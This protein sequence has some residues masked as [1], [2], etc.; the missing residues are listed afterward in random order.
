MTLWSPACCQR[1]QAYV[2]KQ[3]KLTPAPESALMA[4]GIARHWAVL[5]GNTRKGH[6]RLSRNGTVCAALPDDWFTRSAGVLRL[7]ALCL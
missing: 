6:W 5:V 7:V 2:W 3:W 1:L 4:R